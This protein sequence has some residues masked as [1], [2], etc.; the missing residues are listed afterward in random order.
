MINKKL[1]GF[2]FQKRKKIAFSTFMESRKGIS[3][4]L[5]LQLQL[6]QLNG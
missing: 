6:Q 3:E 2:V 1:F 4:D 5:L